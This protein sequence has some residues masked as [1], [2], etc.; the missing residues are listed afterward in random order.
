MFDGRLRLYKEIAARNFG[1]ALRRML[2]SDLVEEDTEI[3]PI[4]LDD[5][6][7]S[8]EPSDD[9]DTPELPSGAMALRAHYVCFASSSKSDGDSPG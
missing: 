2:R 6:A 1:L 3:G 8:H 7:I 4:A 9:E 5:D